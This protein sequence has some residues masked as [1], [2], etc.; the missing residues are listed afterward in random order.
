M[1]KPGDAR[2]ICRAPSRSGPGRRRPSWAIDCGASPAAARARRSCRR[3]RR[4][5]DRR[6]PRRGPG[7]TAAASGSVRRGAPDASRRVRSTRSRLAVVS[8]SPEAGGAAVGAGVAPSASAGCRRDVPRGGRDVARGGRRRGPG[9]A[10]VMGAGRDAGRPHDLPHGGLRRLRRCALRLRRLPR[11]TQRRDGPGTPPASGRAWRPARRP[12]SLAAALLRAAGV[13]A[14]DASTEQ[15]LDGERQAERERDQQR[16]S[17]RRLRPSGI[18]PAGSFP[19]SGSG[20]C[21]AAPCP[22]VS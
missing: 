3:T 4:A 15:R 14:D 16:Q 19:A 1:A 21:A 7:A 13:A 10:G 12:R 2:D 17:A 5:T 8:N 20:R 22:C 6:P 18:S 11:L 9:A